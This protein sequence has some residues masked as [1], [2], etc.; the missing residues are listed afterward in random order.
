MK[1]EVVRV[2]HAA[3]LV[4]SFPVTIDKLDACYVHTDEING[5]GKCI[6]KTMLDV[7]SVFQPKPPSLVGTYIFTEH[8]NFSSFS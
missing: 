4:H 2:K 5:L 6:W 7:T 3:F 8:C 1:H